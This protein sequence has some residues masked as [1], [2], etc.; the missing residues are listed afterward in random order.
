MAYVD[1]TVF[2]GPAGDVTQAITEIQIEATRGGLKLQKAKTQVWSP[3]QA[4][5]NNE[6]RGR[7]KRNSD[8]GETVSEEPEHAIP[9][10]NEASVTD[11]INAIKQK[12]LDDLSKLE[13]SSR[14]Q[15]RGM[16]TDCPKLT[17]AHNSQ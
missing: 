3:Q 12:L 17:Q 11:H 5:I 15:K 7:Q 8:L 2:L 16:T 13:H 9:N 4:S 10:G 14:N 1:D 6:L